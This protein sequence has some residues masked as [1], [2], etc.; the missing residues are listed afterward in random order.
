MTPKDLIQK[1]CRKI[2]LNSGLSERDSNEISIQCSDMYRKSKIKA[3]KLFDEAER[4]SKQKIKL[5][6]QNKRKVR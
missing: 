3:T 4:L 1:E 6:G 5:T 2:A